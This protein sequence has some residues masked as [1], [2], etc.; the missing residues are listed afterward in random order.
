M[1]RILEINDKDVG[2]KENKKAKYRPRTAARA[3][4]FDKDKIALLHVT[5]FK[6]Y[7][8]PGGGVDDGES[9]EG[10][11]VRE[12]N[13]EVGSKIKI[14]EEIG[15]IIEHRSQWELVQT[16][17]CYFAKVTKKGKPNFTQKELDEGFEVVWVGIDEA[18][19]LV[20]NSK[21]GTYHGDF[22]IARDLAFLKMGKRLMK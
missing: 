17:H 9:I 3:I 19:E 5:K 20:K 1:K 2:Q 16:S 10:T 18:I 6:F 12:I 13:E 22:V 14:G 4:L 21:P 11:L 7:K 15:E 8:L